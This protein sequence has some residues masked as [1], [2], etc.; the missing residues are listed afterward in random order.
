MWGLQMRIALPKLFAQKQKWIFCPGDLIESINELDNPMRGWYRIF[1]FYAEETP[2]FENIAWCKNK[3]DSLALVIINIGEFREQRLPDTAL[4]NIRDILRFFEKNRYDVILRITYDHEGNALER[5]PFFFAQV[6]EHAEQISQIIKEF[7]QTIFVYQ[8]MLIGNWGEMHTSRFVTVDKL[9]ELWKILKMDLDGDVFFAVRKP[10]FWRALHPECIDNLQEQHST[11]G[12][13]DDAVFGSPT[14]LGTFGNV[15]KESAPWDG[16]WDYESEMHFEYELCKRVPNGGEALCGE[17]YLE[18]YNPYLTVRTLR[19]MHITYLNKTYD[20]LILDMWKEWKWQEND[21]WNGIN[22]YDYIGNHLGYRFCI[23][24]VEMHIPED[25]KKKILINIKVLNVG[26]A[27]IY[28]ETEVYLDLFYENNG[29]E[30][31][32]INCDMRTWDSGS[33]QD[34][35]CLIPAMDCAIYLSAKYKADGRRIYFAN[36]S[37]K[38]GKVLLGKIKSIK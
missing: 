17:H 23:K 6:K 5:E 11:M 25:S 35:C 18:E 2:D 15:P 4:N 32:H 30:S 1:P 36:Q 14:H 9:K 20:K 19:K 34:V 10:S 29:W 21:P 12:L 24:E 27:N 31:M 7:S 3:E 28:A 38:D 13:F 37:D 26:F 33:I 8:G 16:L 22:M